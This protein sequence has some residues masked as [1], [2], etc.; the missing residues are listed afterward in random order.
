M[1]INENQWTSMKVYE[2]QSKLM[3]IHENRLK[4]MKAYENGM[5]ILAF[6]DADKAVSLQYVCGNTCDL[7]AVTP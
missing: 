1:K 4:S 7:P 5:V 6:L 3:K 2:S